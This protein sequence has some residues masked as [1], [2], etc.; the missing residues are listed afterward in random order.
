MYLLSNGWLSIASR[1][2][3]AF[4]TWLLHELDAFQGDLPAAEVERCQDLVVRRCRRVG[5]V[6]LVERLGHFC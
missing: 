3:I 5:H 2:R 1:S 6:G 4:S